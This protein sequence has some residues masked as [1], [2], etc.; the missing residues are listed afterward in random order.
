M[1]D[2]IELLARGF[3]QIGLPIGLGELGEHPQARASVDGLQQPARCSYAE[4]VIPAAANRLA[5][6]RRH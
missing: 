6:G 5:S 3:P 2:P 1:V 4:E